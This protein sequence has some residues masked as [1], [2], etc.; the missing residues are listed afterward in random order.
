MTNPMKNDDDNHIAN[1]LLK[2]ASRLLCGSGSHIHKQSHSCK[3]HHILF[4]CCKLCEGRSAWV[5]YSYECGKCKDKFCVVHFIEHLQLMKSNQMNKVKINCRTDMLNI[6]EKF[7]QLDYMLKI[8]IH[9]ASS[10]INLMSRVLIQPFASVVVQF[11]RA[12]NVQELGLWI[13]RNI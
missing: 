10:S 6:D 7:M 2:F 8:P 13:I 11:I 4:Y 12:V 9:L 1:G 3:K 5:E